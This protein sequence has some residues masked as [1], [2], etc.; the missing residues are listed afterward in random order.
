MNSPDPASSHHLPSGPDE[1]DA[2]G[3]SQGGRFLIGFLW[4]VLLPACCFALVYLVRYGEYSFPAY[5]ATLMEVDALTKIM[6]LCLLPDLI[7]F[8]Y[9]LRKDAIRPMKGIMA[10]VLLYVL[11]IVIL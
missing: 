4:G 11:A 6:S 5:L 1:S 8:Y 3:G 2:S 9:Y 7:V 10:G